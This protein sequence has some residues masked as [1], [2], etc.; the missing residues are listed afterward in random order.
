M[1]HAPFPI[2]GPGGSIIETEPFDIE[3]HIRSAI[4]EF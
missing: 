4:S 2:Y 3:T 1:H